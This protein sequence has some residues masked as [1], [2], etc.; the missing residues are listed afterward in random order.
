M[1]ETTSQIATLSAKDA[2]V[3]IGSAGKPLL[4]ADLKIINPDKDD[5]G[6]IIVKGP[7]VTKGYFKN[8]AA[9]KQKIIDGWLHTGDLGYLDEAGYLYVVDR[10]TDLIIS[11]GE[12]I[13]P[14][15]IENALVKIPQIKEAG[16]VGVADDTWGE[17]PVA[18]VVLH[19]PI[20]KTDIL[21]K[22]SKQLAK[23]KLPKKIKFIDEMP[24]NASN[25][26]VR[27]KLKEL[28]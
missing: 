16:V 4:P 12:N 1:T 20:S 22:L 13:Y 3:K 2:L 27:K 6:E 23:Y 11:G 9:N 10:R 28:E 25:K 14:S 24:R 17:V 8:E 19:E 5:V 26:L 7:M 18:Y 15:E 21:Q